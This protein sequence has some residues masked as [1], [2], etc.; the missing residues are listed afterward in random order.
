MR[1]NGEDKLQ[2]VFVDFLNKKILA[3]QSVC[4]GSE[5]SK[6]TKTDVLKNI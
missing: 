5:E 1:F 4:T 6:R 3:V 2:I